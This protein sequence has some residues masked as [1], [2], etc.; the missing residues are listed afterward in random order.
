MENPIDRR[1]AVSAAVAGNVLEWYDLAV[2]AFVATTMGAKFFPGGDQA[3][4]VLGSF[5]AYGLGFV[6]RPLG[7]IVLGRLGDTHG[8]RFAL[9]VTI[10]LMAGGTVMIGLL[11][12]YD[13][14]GPLATILLVVARLTQGFSA[15]GDWGCSTAFIVEWAPDGRRGWYGSFQQTSVVAGLLLGSGVAA[16]LTTLVS[17]AAMDAWGWRVPFLLGAVLGPVGMYMR[18]AVEETPRYQAAVATPTPAPAGARPWLLAA[19]AFGFTVVWTVSYYILLNYMPTWAQQHLGFS[20]SRALGSNT[21]GL[22]LLLVAIP[23]MGRLSDRWGRKPLLLTCCLAFILVPYPVFGYLVGVGPSFGALVTVQVGFALLISMFSGPGPAAIAE[24]FPTR[25]RSTWM[26][27]G[28]AFAVT[29][30]GG[31]APFISVWLIQRFAS[32]T[33]HSFYLMAAAV[34]SAAVIATMPETAFDELR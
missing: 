3:T 2:Y 14:V 23:L 34:V 11:P 28:Y 31:F 4:A 12:T 13:S 15:G 18:R 8:R 16:V 24:I 17:P 29:I 5:L 32:P 33:V 22:L 20:A 9:L 7:A 30:F 25:Q 27:T 21:I 1:R 26:T 6:A 19:R 10:F